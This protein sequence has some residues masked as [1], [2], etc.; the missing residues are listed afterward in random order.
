MLQFKEDRLP[1]RV[2]VLCCHSLVLRHSL[3]LPSYF[4]SFS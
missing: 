1:S 2:A 3:V 4:D